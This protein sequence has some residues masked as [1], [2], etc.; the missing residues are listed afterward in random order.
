MRRH[1]GRSHSRHGLPVRVPAILLPLLL[2]TPPVLAV[3]QYSPPPGLVEELDVP[4]EEPLPP[5]PQELPVAP[6]G[7]VVTAPDA[8]GVV[9]SCEEAAFTDCFRLWRP[10]VPPTEKAKADARNAAAAASRQLAV[11]GALDA[12]PPSA[13]PSAAVQA[14]Q[15]TYE[16]LMRALKDTGLEGKILVSDPRAADAAS[17]SQNKPQNKPVP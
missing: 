7:P 6:I 10:P 15:A 11:G 3:G 16:A 4:P 17:P 1:N 5:E 8:H 2:A 9:T 14:D 12:L 13:L